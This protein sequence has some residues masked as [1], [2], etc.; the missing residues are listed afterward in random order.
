MRGTLTFAPKNPATFSRPLAPVFQKPPMA[1]IPALTTP[2]IVSHTALTL[3]EIASQ[4]LSQMCL[5]PFIAS[6]TASFISSNLSLTNF[7]TPPRTRV[8]TRSTSRQVFPVLFEI[9][10]HT[11]PTTLEIA[12]KIRLIGLYSALTAF[13]TV[14]DNERQTFEVVLLI[15]FQAD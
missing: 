7:Q 1:L 2:L 6:S 13:R 15:V 9:P 4:M 5:M 3:S 10:F 12:L 11:R 8:I 14:R